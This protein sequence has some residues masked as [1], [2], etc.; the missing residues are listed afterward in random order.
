M[1]TLLILLISLSFAGV[2]SS[3]TPAAADI[4]DKVRARYRSITDV[5]ADFRQTVTLRYR[6]KG[7]VTAGSAHVKKGNKFRINSDQQTIVCDG[8][9]LWMYTPKSQQVLIDSYRGNRQAFSPDRF[10]TGLPKEFVAVSHDRNGAVYTLRLKPSEEA[11]VYANIV[12]LTVWTTEGEWLADSIA[13]AE[14]NGT[15][16]TIALRN[17]R[18]NSGIADETFHFTV[19]PEMHV[20]EMKNIP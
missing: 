16:T 14:K 19:T 8:S 3:Q 7:R 10:L 6:P 9:T 2:L 17:I 5:S 13:M 11:S 15:T 4:L 18:F 20:V 12:T 1:R